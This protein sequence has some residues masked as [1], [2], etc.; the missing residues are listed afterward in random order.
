MEKQDLLVSMTIDDNFLG[1]TS[2]CNTF[3][4][5]LSAFHFKTTTKVGKDAKGN[6]K[7]NTRTKSVKGEKKSSK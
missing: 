4:L 6:G 3:F 2:H 1:K 5:S 7:G